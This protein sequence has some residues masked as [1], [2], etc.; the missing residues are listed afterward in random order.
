MSHARRELENN[1][2][3]RGNYDNTETCAVD[4]SELE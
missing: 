3:G 4:C 2:K 1:V